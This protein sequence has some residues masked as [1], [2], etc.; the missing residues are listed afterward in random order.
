M[1]LFSIVGELGS[2]KTLALTY[3]AWHNWFHR[4]R[5]IFS[6]YNLYGFPFTKVNT[7]PDLDSIKEGF[8]AF[9]E[10]W[11][12]ISSWSRSKQIEFITS[13][14]LKSRKRHL[15]ISFTTQTIA[16]INKRIREVTDFLAYA[17]MSTDNSYTRLE[18]FRGPRA[19]IGTRI[20]PPIY[21]NNEPVYAMFNTY[22]EVKPLIPK[23]EAEQMKLPICK[24]MFLPII[25]N[26][27][28]IR[29]LKKEKGITTRD[30]IIKY[31]NKIMDVIN[32]DRITSESQREHEEF[33]A[34]LE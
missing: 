16:Q 5:R 8:C 7:V 4:N 33:E 12:S 17:L 27:A 1:V 21:F 13:I 20:N 2:G 29:Y 15:T 25:E 11:L 32:P 14:L 30:K 24:E 22:E 6:N 31:S 10:L 26:P 34:T 19:S 3:L 28:W 18:I 9:D 23:E